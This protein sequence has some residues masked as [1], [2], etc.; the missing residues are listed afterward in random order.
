MLF[1]LTHLCTFHPTATTHPTCVFP[2]LA[3]DTHIVGPTSYVLLIFL[4]LQEEFGALG[5]LVQSSKCVA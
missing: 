3:N 1:A 5:L 2:S 4:Q